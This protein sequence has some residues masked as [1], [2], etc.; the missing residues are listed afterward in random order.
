MRKFTSDTLMP[1]GLCITAIGFAYVVGIW[2][3]QVD[4]RLDEMVDVSKQIT[5]LQS[6]V[7]ILRQDIEV[8]K[9]E[10][11]RPT[12]DPPTRGRHSR[13]GSGPG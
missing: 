12:T 5:Y 10:S 9:N 4:R 8:I 7:M 1:M 13:S 6:Q 11:H 3:G 2:K